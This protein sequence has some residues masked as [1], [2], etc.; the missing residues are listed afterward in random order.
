MA[1]HCLHWHTFTCHEV[2]IEC[3]YTVQAF[4]CSFI[5]FL[6]VYIDEYVCIY[7]V[8]LIVYFMFKYS[9]EFMWFTYILIDHAYIVI[10]LPCA[11][12]LECIFVTIG[13]DFKYL[14]LVWEAEPLCI[15]GLACDTL[16][17]RE[18]FI[19]HLQLQCIFDILDEGD[20]LVWND[21]FL[22]VT[23]VVGLADFMNECFD[24]LC[25]FL[26][27]CFD[28]VLLLRFILVKL[29]NTKVIKYVL[30]ITEFRFNLADLFSVYFGFQ[31]HL[32]RPISIILNDFSNLV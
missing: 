19:F 1:V 31:F 12:L 17:I 5:G 30:N 14:F 7:T 9:L 11:I 10:K 26:L 23:L 2:F 29:L 18:Q 22:A 25:Q 20:L 24:I 15:H 28:I 32:F 3:N 16:F 4:K 13:V 21:P 8:I 6:S 27:Q